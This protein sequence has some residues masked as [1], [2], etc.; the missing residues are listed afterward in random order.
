[1]ML[2]W[3]VEVPAE[4][5]D[6]H[7]SSLNRCIFSYF[8]YYEYRRLD[9]AVMGNT[10]RVK[11]FITFMKKI[12]EQFRHHFSRSKI[13]IEICMFKVEFVF[14][15]IA[16]QKSWRHQ[17]VKRRR[18]FYYFMKYRFWRNRTICNNHGTERLINTRY[19]RSNHTVGMF[20]LISGDTPLF[21]RFSCFI[22]I[23]ETPLPVDFEIYFKD[24]LVVEYNCL[25]TLHSF[26]RYT[27]E[28]KIRE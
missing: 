23:P 7:C 8:E 16:T 17:F 18:G 6:L 22:I 11:Y 24:S 5:K 15:D 13:I 12:V 9:Q 4:K 3:T 2:H 19:D 25:S 10:R 20:G 27:P 26:T 28:Y 14:T 21:K 1:M